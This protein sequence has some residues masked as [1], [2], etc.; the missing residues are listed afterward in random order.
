M[1]YDNE[2]IRKLAYKLWQ[3]RSYSGVHTSDEQDWI[4]AEKLYTTKTWEEINT[5]IANIPLAVA[6]EEYLDEEVE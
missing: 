1:T 4:D 3:V 2:E 6:S 5:Y